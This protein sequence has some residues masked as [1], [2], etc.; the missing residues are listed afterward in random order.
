MIIFSI[1]ATLMFDLWEI[2]NTQS[3][4]IFNDKIVTTAVFT[5]T[6]KYFKYLKVKKWKATRDNSD[7]L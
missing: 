2:F 4:K 7:D 5:N 3:C 6:K 1:I